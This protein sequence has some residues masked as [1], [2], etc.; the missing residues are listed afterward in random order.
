MVLRPLLNNIYRAKQS[1]KDI[2]EIESGL[3]EGSIC[4]LKNKLKLH[5]E[6]FIVV[7]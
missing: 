3:P 4:S 6:P 5:A 7:R 1:D 2:R